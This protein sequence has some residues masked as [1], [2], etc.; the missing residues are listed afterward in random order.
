MRNNF[1][2]IQVKER[3]IHDIMPN[4]GKIKNKGNSEKTGERAELKQ[5]N[6][7]YSTDK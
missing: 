4:Q 3:N 7:N 1:R 6:Q 5:T 2:F